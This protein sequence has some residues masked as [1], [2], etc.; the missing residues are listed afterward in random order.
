MAIRELPR[1]VSYVER[2]GKT[3]LKGWV[4]EEVSVFLPRTSLPSK[5]SLEL[6][7]ETVGDERARIRTNVY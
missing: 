7:S 5:A 6:P 3:K 2:D 4:V 1:R